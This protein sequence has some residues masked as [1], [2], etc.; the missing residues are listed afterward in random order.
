MVGA[1]ISTGNT[2]GDTVELVKLCAHNCTV[3]TLAGTMPGSIGES[4]SV[5][6]KA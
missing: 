5:G 6:E 4:G 1:V 3:D 2:D